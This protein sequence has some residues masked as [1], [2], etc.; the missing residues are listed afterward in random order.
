MFRPN[1]LSIVMA[2]TIVA[3]LLLCNNA[4]AYVGPGSG[5]EFIGY[6]MSLFAMIA[7]A[8]FSFLMWPFYALMRWLRGARGVQVP[9]TNEQSTAPTPD[10]VAPSTT[11]PSGQSD[12][13][14][15]TLQP[16]SIP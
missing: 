6:A 8:F 9:T 11:S 12:N 10:A 7:I 2:W 16:H 5:M 15:G 3:T 13:N 1:R 4:L 14:P